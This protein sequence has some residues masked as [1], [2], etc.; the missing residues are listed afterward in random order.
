MHPYR[1]FDTST[2]I[3]R[4]CSGK[5]YC[6]YPTTSPNT[7]EAIEC[8][9]PAMTVIKIIARITALA[10]DNVNPIITTSLLA[11]YAPHTC[12]VCDKSFPSYQ[13]LSGHKTRNRNRPPIT[14][15]IVSDVTNNNSTLNV[16]T[17]NPSDR[18]HQCF[19]CNNTFQLARLWGATCGGTVMVRLAVARKIVRSLLRTV[20]VATTIEILI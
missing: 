5:S 7:V 14:I 6:S 3:V 11:Q 15:T 16:S 18:I 13:A 12:I 1:R 17:L 9:K 2:L 8:K 19:T 20:P 4:V 10:L